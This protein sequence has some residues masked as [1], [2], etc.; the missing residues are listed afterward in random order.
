[1]GAHRATAGGKP[2]ATKP[3]R[4]IKQKGKKECTKEAKKEQQNRKTGEE[5]RPAAIGR[6]RRQEAHSTSEE[7]DQL[8]LTATLLVVHMRQSVDDP[9]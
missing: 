2:R 1:M 9:K 4:E 7:D 8:R 6:P 5:R 3:E